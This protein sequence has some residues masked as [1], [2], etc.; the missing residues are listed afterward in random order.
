M[1]TLGLGNQILHDC[2][3]FFY[4]F[5]HMYE[6]AKIFEFCKQSGLLWRLHLSLLKVI[7]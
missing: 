4:L 6:M 2:L 5:V 1:T 7:G 3:L